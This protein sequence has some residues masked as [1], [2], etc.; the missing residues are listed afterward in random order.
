M[1]RPSLRYDLVSCLKY[2]KLKYWRRFKATINHIKIAES[3]SNA[4]DD[5]SDDIDHWKQLLDLN[6]D[7]MRMEHL[8]AKMYVVVFKFLA[9]IMIKWS[10]KSSLGRLVRSFDS[11][12]FKDEIEIEKQSLQALE[13]KLER[14]DRLAMHRGIMD[15]AEMIKLGQADFRRELRMFEDR[16]GR[17]QATNLERQLQDWRRELR[18]SPLKVQ[19]RMRPQ[20]NTRQSFLQAEGSQPPMSLYPI[21][22]LQENAL[23]R[24]RPYTAQVHIAEMVVQAS[25]QNVHMD[26]FNGI[27]QWNAVSASSVLWV[28]GPF[29]VPQPSP[30]TQLSAYVIMTAQK[31]NL[32]VIYYFCDSTKSMVDLIYTLIG[33]L[34]GLIPGDFHSNLDFSGPRF[35]T[36]DCRSGSIQQAITLFKDLVTEGPH[37]LFV[38][39]DGIQMLDTNSELVQ[40]RDL[41]DVLRYADKER[42]ENRIHLIKTLFTTDGLTDALI[43]LPDDERID[44][45]DF[46]GEEGP[47]SEIDAIEV[48]FLL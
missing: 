16:M 32:P 41:V 2:L 26:L 34:V 35:D 14:S 3:V 24:L 33:Q 39:I 5:L 47:E 44:C 1:Y 37:M 40:I 12:F 21:D 18:E 36:L 25:L 11:D 4:L 15:V 9:T 30:F 19:I 7:N 8:V 23:Q 48:G 43:H 13:Q 10:S 17:T 31:A 27:Q 29:Q 20:S 6:N 28:Q 46:F 45:T 42:N 38:V 22:Q